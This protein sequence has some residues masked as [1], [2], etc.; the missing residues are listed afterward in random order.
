MTAGGSP[1]ETV[2]TRR[3]GPMRRLMSV[4][5]ELRE[6]RDELLRGG[7]NGSS[8]EAGNGPDGAEASA[9]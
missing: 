4:A 8:G 7:K 9:S 5:A 6:K 1:W 2:E 3:H